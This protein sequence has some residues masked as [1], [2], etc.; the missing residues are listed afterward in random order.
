MTRIRFP[1]LAVAATLFLSLL[2]C[3]PVVAIGWEELI[4]LILLIVLLLGP[5]L[6]RLARAWNKFQETLKKER[7]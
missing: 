2:A 6:F 5:L 1:V 3:R 7:H 4:V